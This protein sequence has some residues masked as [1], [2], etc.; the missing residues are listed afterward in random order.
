MSSVPTQPKIDT[1]KK[2]YLLLLLAFPLLSNA[3]ITIGTND[4]TQSGQQFIVSQG[5][6][7]S[8]MDATLTGPNYNWDYSQLT[9]TSQTT[10][11]IFDESATGSLLSVYFFDNFINPNRSNQASHG[12]SFNLGTVNVSDVWNFYYNSTTSF[13]QTGF[14]AIVNGAPLPVAY[15]PHDIIFTLPLNYGDNFSGNSGYALDL[16][17][18]LGLYYSISKSRTTDVDGWGS[19]TTPL[20]TYQV[21]RTKATVVEVDSVYID[22][23]GFGLSLPPITTTEYKW[24]AGGE[25]IPVLQINTTGTGIVTSIL[26]KDTLNTTNINQLAVIGEP[27]VFPNPASENLFVKYSL[28]RSSNIQ[29]TILSSDGKVIMQEEEQ[30]VLAGDQI[31]ILPISQYHLAD[32]NYFLKV[33][34]GKHSFT[35]SFQAGR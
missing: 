2:I 35:K 7:F 18:T 33:S 16:T 19:V 27:V 12:N 6:A 10:D 13:T 1:M 29:F 17:S 9:Y 23:L 20:G 32:G 8:G 15:N 5:A 31:K 24:L 4:L 30:G 3:Q 14:G 21:L 22:S 34:N 25:G 28:D 26:Y 11:T